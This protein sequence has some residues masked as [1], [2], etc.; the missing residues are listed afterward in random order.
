MLGLPC[1]NFTQKQKNIRL[2][3][4]GICIFDGRWDMKSQGHNQDPTDHPRWSLSRKQIMASLSNWDLSKSPHPRYSIWSWKHLHN[5]IHHSR[6][7]LLSTTFK[8]ILTLSAEAH[9]KSSWKSTKLLPHEKKN[10]YIYI[11]I[12]TYSVKPTTYAKQIPTADENRA[13]NAPLIGKKTKSVTTR[14]QER[15]PIPQKLSLTDKIP[16][17]PIILQTHRHRKMLSWWSLFPQTDRTL[18]QS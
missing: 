16:G 7:L 13:P 11:Y 4:W 14:Q 12:C 1:Q 18:V 17:G 9:L 8:L 6:V 10:I 2:I 5:T 3:R 15:A